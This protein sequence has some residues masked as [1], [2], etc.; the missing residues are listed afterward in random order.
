M[1]L[2]HGETSAQL[3]NM[4]PHQHVIFI[5]PN[6]N[7][8][9]RPNLNTHSNGANAPNRVPCEI[10][11][12]QQTEQIAGVSYYNLRTCQMWRTTVIDNPNYEISSP[13]DVEVWK[14]NLAENNGISFLPVYVD[15]KYPNLLAY[16]AYSCNIKT[17]RRE[18]FQNLKKVKELDLDFNK[19]ETIYSD[20]FS[21]LESV[22]IIH[23]GDVEFAQFSAI[24]Q[25]LMVYSYRWQQNQAD[26][27]QTFR[28]TSQ[29]EENLVERQ[30]MP[31]WAN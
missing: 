4:W 19:I 2:A 3:S 15:Q 17:L 10:I 6:V 21:G 29:F 28:T 22:E 11:N 25:V 8:Y 12:T 7:T 26:E 1:L 31:R 18:N 13:R 30:P 9:V 27:R 20:V 5:R 24:F 14:L 23:L 16:T